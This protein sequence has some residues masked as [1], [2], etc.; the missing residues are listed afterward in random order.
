MEWGTR[1]VDWLTTRQSSLV[2][3]VLPSPKTK[4]RVPR[5]SILRVQPG[6]GGDVLERSAWRPAEAGRTAPP[7]PSE[8][9]YVRLRRRGQ[10]V[11]TVV[12]SLWGTPG[13]VL[14]SK[15]SL[16]TSEN[17]RLANENSKR[18]LTDLV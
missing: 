2:L 7:L 18:N 8:L 15:V 16:R 6:K 9:P 5:A 11:D 13:I 12:A 14:W 1:G 3:T 4:S 10:P 17:V